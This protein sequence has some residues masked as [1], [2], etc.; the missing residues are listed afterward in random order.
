[1]S[2]ALQRQVTVPFSPGTERVHLAIEPDPGLYAD[3]LIHLRL[4]P[5]VAASLAAD[6]GEVWAGNSKLIDVAP[7]V[8]QFSGSDTAQLP[9][10]PVDS[11]PEF[12]VLFAFDS[13]GQP[14][15]A[16]ASC[17]PASGTVR[18]SRSC[19]AAV[20]Y[21]AYKAGARM[22]TYRPKTEALAGGASTIYGVIAAYYQG[23]LVIYQV[24]PS[25]IERGDA[26]I[27]LYRRYSYKAITADGEFEIPPNYPTSGA[28]PGKS[29]VLDVTTSLKIERVHEIGYL[30]PDGRAEVRTPTVSVLE[31][32]VGDFGYKP[33]IECRIATLS[34]SQYPKDVIARA[35][36][37][38]KSKGLG[39]RG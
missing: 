10:P 20:S 31:P 1:V 34:P 16:S 19:T 39:C 21:T 3:A 15:G 9:A 30:D 26:M 29:L 38:V 14:T 4:V 32:Y 12:N 33:K 11:A 8:F 23:A 25:T 17:D 24:Q 6:V 35:Q 18:L 22:L 27:E 2:S 28:Y 37:F 13:K 7:G 36:D 5:D